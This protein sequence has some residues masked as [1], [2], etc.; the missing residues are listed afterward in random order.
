M[1]NGC[2]RYTKER[3]IN[4]K[5]KEDFADEKKIVKLLLL[6][7][8]GSGK[9]TILRQMKIIHG[10]GYSVKERLKRREAVYNNVMFGTASIIS[11]M[12][13]LSIHY[14]SPDVQ[15]SADKIM[16][17]IERPYGCR[18]LNAQIVQAVKAV[19]E[20]NAVQKNLLP[21]S[22]EFQFTE[23][24]TYFVNNIERISQKK[25]VPNVKDILMLRITTTGINEF[26]FVYK[27]VNFRM[28]DIGG[29]RSE[30]R[31]WVDYFDNVQAILFVVAISEFDQK[32]QEDGSTNRLVESTRL[33]QFVCNI[34]RFNDIAIVL[35]LNKVDLF[36]EK[37]KKTSINCAFRNYS[38]AHTYDAQIKFIV[39][40]FKAYNR[41]PNKPIYTHETCATDTKK[42]GLI[43]E[44]VIDSLF[45]KVIQ[46]YALL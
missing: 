41:I 22:N 37:I 43:L 15:N 33:F 13:T 21:R 8:G 39:Q 12:S 4:Q 26:N 6:G 9:S 30:R 35:F 20:D 19:W 25:Y 36:K 44:N 2:G 46:S 16:Q 7:A 34:E 10:N 1:G 29:Q 3:A 24:Y 27:N 40:K 31:K 17:E 45:E 11:G 38:G 32:I 18:E 23:S 42:I 5:L 14:D 28:Y